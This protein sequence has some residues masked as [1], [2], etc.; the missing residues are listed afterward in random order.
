MTD[1]T[2]TP[3]NDLPRSA[4][5]KEQNP[6]RRAIRL[7]TRT[8]EL[9]HEDHIPDYD[10]APQVL[11]WGERVFAGWG[12]ADDGTTR[13]YREA[14]ALALEAI[15]GRSAEY[16]RSVLHAEAEDDRAGAAVIELYHV[17]DEDEYWIRLDQITVRLVTNQTDP[18]ARREAAMGVA[19]AAAAGAPDSAIIKQGARMLPWLTLR[20]QE[21]SM[22]LIARHQPSTDHQP[23]SQ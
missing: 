4:E 1:S 14:R 7:E 9:V 19:E 3:M 20:R 18:Q 8:G 5:E 17:P 2:S 13:I 21:E 16:A 6:P 10:H 22:S 15:G 12:W 11:F 23:P